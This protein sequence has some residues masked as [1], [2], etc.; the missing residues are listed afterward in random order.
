MSPTGALGTLG[1][2]EAIEN[3]ERAIMVLAADLGG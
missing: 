2:W 1:K 3:T